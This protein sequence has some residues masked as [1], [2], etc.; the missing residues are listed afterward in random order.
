MIGSHTHPIFHIVYVMLWPSL[1]EET[2]QG[3]IEEN[4][5]LIASYAKIPPFAKC[6]RTY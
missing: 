6:T 2:P 3:N 1:E 5:R 4:F